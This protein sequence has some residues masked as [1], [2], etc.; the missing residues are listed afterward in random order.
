MIAPAP[1]PILL[2]DWERTIIFTPRKLKG[3][4]GIA[5]IRA[6]DRINAT[7][8]RGEMLPQCLKVCQLALQQF[9]GHRG[10]YQEVLK[11]LIAAALRGQ[12]DKL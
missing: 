11:A 5:I 10:T 2:T 12:G 9:E 1:I 7:S 8:G 4:A 3:G 6:R